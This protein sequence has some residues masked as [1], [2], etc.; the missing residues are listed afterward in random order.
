MPKIICCQKCSYTTSKESN[1]Q[2][3]LSTRKHQELMKV[4]EQLITKVA[5]YKCNICDKLYTSNVGLWKHKKKCKSN[6]PEES[7]QNETEITDSRQ[8]IDFLRQENTEFKKM[9]LDLQIQLV[10]MC[11]NMCTTTNNI[12]NSNSH[13][14]TFNLQFFL[15]EQCKDAMNITEFVQ[16]LN[17]E[18]E[19]LESLGEL[20]YVEGMTN[21]FAKR[22]KDIDVYKRPIHCSDAKR[23]IIHI[24]HDNVWHKEEPGNPIF[25]N[26]VKMV[27][28]GNFRLLGQW[29]A[30][31]PESSQY[32]SRW[33]DVYTKLLKETSGG[34]GDY[35]TNNDTIMRRLSRLVVINKT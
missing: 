26:A 19:D 5:E 6:E 14:K 27:V 17:L 32:N 18:M 1:Y 3:H 8:I 12:T 33:S 9:I 15:N 10:D 13:N 35:E 21:I 25:R 7:K 20:G 29:I 4:N 31:H 23:E 30:L 2:K 24:K 22:L 28:G 16:S 34:H 11:K